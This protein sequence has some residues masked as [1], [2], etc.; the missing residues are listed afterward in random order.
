LRQHLDR[1]A[2]GR[3]IRSRQQRGMLVDFHRQMTLGG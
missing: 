1:V 3:G 2:L